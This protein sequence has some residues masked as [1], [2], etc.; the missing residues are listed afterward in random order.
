MKKS[1]FYLVL[2]TL[3]FLFCADTFSQP[4]EDGSNNSAV[5]YATVSFLNF[6]NGVTGGPNSVNKPRVQLSTTSTTSDNQ[7]NWTSENPFQ[8]VYDGTKLTSTVLTFSKDHSS[9]DLGILNY[10]QFNLKSNQKDTKITLEDFTIQGHNYG[11]FVADG[12]DNT[13]K[14]LNK[15]IASLT[16]TGSFTIS[17]KI[18]LDGTQP[19]SSTVT[20]SIGRLP[21]SDGEAPIVSNVK[22]LPPYAVVGTDIVLTANVDDSNTGNSNIASAEYSLDLTDWIEMDPVDGAY[23]EPTEDVADTLM[24]LT[25]DN[26][27]IYVRGKDA[28]GNI[29]DTISVDIVLFEL[30]SV[31]GI[32]DVGGSGVGEV[33]VK[34]LKLDGSP[35]FVSSTMTN[36]S[37]G[38]YEFTD[39]EPMQY[40]VEIVTPLG[41]SADEEMKDVM[42]PYCSNDETVNFTLT[43]VPILNAAR[44]KGYWKNQFDFYIR[45]KGNAQE[46][47]ADL[48][49]YIAA[50]GT[51][52]IPHFTDIFDEDTTAQ[53]WSDILSYGG[54]NMYLKAKA[55]LATLILNM[56]SLKISQTEIVTADGR[57][58]ADVITHASTIMS[59]PGSTN[60]QLELAKDIAE[61]ASNQVIIAAGKVPDYNI[62][63]KTG[64][65]DNLPTKYT[66]YSN[67]PNPF[68]PTTVIRYAIPTDGFVTLKVYDLLGREIASLVNEKLE[69]GI[70]SV[71][72]D[73]SK[74]SSGVYIYKMQVNNFTATKKMILIR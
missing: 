1:F 2:F 11:D 42:I 56:A 41:F 14:I 68:N 71:N 12:N 5:I 21:V 22:A 20:F 55:H 15:Y 18:K 44:G 6:D 27:T 58:V 49:S 10:I 7:F 61:A 28:L 39:L 59:T 36:T 43:A 51:H 73:A 48:K 3:M 30:G 13:T 37:I 46:A 52:Y 72:F 67:Y 34:L 74:L 40:R 35:I 31:S 53:Y 66:L 33:T 29:S 19:T 47:W 4:V 23:D 57:D 26:Y 63:Y 70:Y 45:H 50:I 9:G 62:L 24:G 25:C 32:I 16:L 54:P 8:I 65:S 69:Q 38:H 64:A 17:G 60:A